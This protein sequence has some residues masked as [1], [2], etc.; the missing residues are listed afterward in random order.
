MDHEEQLTKL[1]RNWEMNCSRILK[2]CTASNFFRNAKER[3]I[4]SKKTG[5]GKKNYLSLLPLRWNFFISVQWKD[6]EPKYKRTDKNMRDFLRQTVG[7]R[8]VRAFYQYYKKNEKK[9]IIVLKKSW[10]STI[11]FKSLMS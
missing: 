10:L 9:V 5:F 11:K 7:S 1:G 4:M 3:M 6:E 2:T 8:K